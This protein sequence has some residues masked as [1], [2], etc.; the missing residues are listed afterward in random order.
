MIG[1]QDHRKMNK[2]LVNAAAAPLLNE[3]G[4]AIA[5]LLLLHLKVGA[6]GLTALIDSGAMHNIISKQAAAHF[7]AKSRLPNAVPLTVELANG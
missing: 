2:K 6:S 1:C 3:S 5:P 7:G 4:C